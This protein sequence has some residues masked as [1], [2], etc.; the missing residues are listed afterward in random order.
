MSTIENNKTMRI[1]KVRLYKAIFFKYCC[2]RVFNG[3]RVLSFIPIRIFPNFNKC[4]PWIFFIIVKHKKSKM[5][6]KKISLEVVHP[7]AAG[8]DIGSRSHWVAVGQNAEDVK[9]F[10]VYSNDQTA[11]I[12]NMV[13]KRLTYQPPTQYLYL[14]EK[15][16][17]G[18]LKRIRKQI[19]KFAITNVDLG[20]AT[21]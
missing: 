10:G 2:V 12:W 14:D 7:N 3:E 5:E 8:I 16:K 20:M 4:N 11:I 17:L 15:R 21:N 18:L 19:D 6:E 13:T 9:A 1:I